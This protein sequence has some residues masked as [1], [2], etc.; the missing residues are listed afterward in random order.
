M[1]RIGGH[2]QS[3]LYKNRC[4]LKIAI[5]CFP[6]GEVLNQEDICYTKVSLLKIGGHVQSC[7]YRNR[8]TLKITISCSLGGEVFCQEDICFTKVNLLIIGGR[9]Q[10]CLYRNRS[11]LLYHADQEVKSFVKRIFAT[12]R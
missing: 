6:R 9:V 7:L 8:C 3:C 10:S 11:R 1:L 2:A 5:S 12:L 4:S